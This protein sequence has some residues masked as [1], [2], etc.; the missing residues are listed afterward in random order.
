MEAAIHKF[1]LEA[2]HGEAA[3]HAI[4]H[5]C[6]EAFLN[7]G[8]ELLGDVTAGDAVDE[9]QSAFLEVLVDG[10]DVDDDVGELTTAARLLLVDLAVVDGG[11]DGFLV[12]DLGL[13][14]VAFHLEFALQT[15]DD[16]V[17]VQLAHAADDGL[18]ALLVGADG[19]GGV[20]FGKF[21]KAVAELV[22]VLLGLGL[23]G[24][25]DDGIGEVHGL[26][27]DGCVLIGEG[28]AGVDVLEAY[29]SADVACADAIDRVLV[30]GV[31]LEEAA[32]A[33]LLA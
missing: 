16:D 30:V 25:A 4:L 8:D 1:H 28:I 26:E 21:G 2:V 19:E 6:L 11:R 7:A 29:S 13:T 23:H 18:A 31:H 12:V 9:L 17:E 15:V 3:E 33:F 32:D 24:N 5:G 14:L 22:E 27:R 20:L 10:A